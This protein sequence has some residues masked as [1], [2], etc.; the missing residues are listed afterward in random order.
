MGFKETAKNL[1]LKIKKNP[2]WLTKKL[3]KVIIR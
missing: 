3:N 2:R 1:G